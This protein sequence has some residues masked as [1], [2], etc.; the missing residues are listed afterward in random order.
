VVIPRDVFGN[1]ADSFIDVLSKFVS[2]AAYIIE[3]T[4][5]SEGSPTFA[6]NSSSEPVTGLALMAAVAWGFLRFYKFALEVV[7]KQISGSSLTHVGNASS[8]L[9]AIR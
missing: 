9:P 3:V 5:G 6:Y 8:S 1:R 2:I 4:T 7:E